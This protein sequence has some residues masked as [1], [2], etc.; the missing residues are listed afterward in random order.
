[1]IGATSASR[2]AVNT[3]DLA[4]RV[5][6]TLGLDYRVLSG[7]E[8]AALT[9]RG[10]LAMVPGVDAAC[11]LDI[12]GGSMEV[13]VGRVGEPPQYRISL[14]V[15]SVR[16]TERFFRTQPPTSV[17]IADAERALDAVF[18]MIPQDIAGGLPLVEGGGTARVLAALAQVTERVPVIPRDTVRTWR[19][20]L[21]KLTPDEVRALAPGLLTGREDVTAMAALLLDA[22]MRRFGFEDFIASPGGLRHGLALEAV[23]GFRV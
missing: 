6:E 1:M 10:T 4:D 5:R 16:L 18:G 22:V 11:V 21:L 13:V 12:G 14:D 19:D 7:E 15:G 2:D 20:R 23:E 9:F 8:E 17:Q 3:P